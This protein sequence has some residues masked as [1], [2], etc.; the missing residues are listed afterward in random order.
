MVT[1]TTEP[2]YGCITFLAK[3]VVAI[4][5]VPQRMKMDLQ[6]LM[7]QVQRGAYVFTKGGVGFGRHED[8]G[9]VWYQVVDWDPVE[10]A[11]ILELDTLMRKVGKRG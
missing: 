8:G 3:E 6:F 1:D 5:E 4:G 11:L 9:H 2:E 7:D 10:Q